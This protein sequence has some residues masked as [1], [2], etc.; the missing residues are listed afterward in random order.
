MENEKD[1]KEYELTSEKVVMFI[2]ELVLIISGCAALFA[3]I[4]G[5]WYTLRCALT[6]FFADLIGIG[7]GY[8]LAN[9]FGKK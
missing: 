2:F 3:L 9:I 1:P 5:S 6:V 7:F 4:W 8:S